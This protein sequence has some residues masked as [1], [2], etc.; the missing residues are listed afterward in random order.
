M[1]GKQI[2]WEDITEGSE[3]PTAYS[4]AIT[5]TLIV[6]QVDGT[7]DY[8]LVHHDVD[9]ARSTGV[10]TIFLNTGFISA[11]LCRLITDWVGDD[12][13][14]QRLHFEMRRMAHLGDTVS[15]KGKI[16]KKYIE[17]NN[18]CVDCDVWIENQ[19]GE[20]TTPGKTTVI[21]PTKS[22]H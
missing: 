19:K 9:H 8:N 14:L 22:G 16:T 2:L 20:I 4:L 21:L 10:P 17:G 18:H 15:A 12:G 13:W 6:E 5:P 7:Q 3:I 11:M 1:S